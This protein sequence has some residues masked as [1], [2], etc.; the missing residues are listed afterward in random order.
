[1]D[2]S[3]AVLPGLKNSNLGSDGAE[4]GAMLQTE[5]ANETQDGYELELGQWVR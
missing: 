4:G 1:M 2:L 3:S 5:A